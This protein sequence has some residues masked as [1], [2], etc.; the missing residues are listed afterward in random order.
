M[1]TTKMLDLEDY[2]KKDYRIKKTIAI[3]KIYYKF[4]RYK[5]VLKKRKINSNRYK[6]N[7]NKVNKLKTNRSNMIES[8]K[9]NKINYANFNYK[10]KVVNYLVYNMFNK[11]KFPFRDKNKNSFYFDLLI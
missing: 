10:V 3:N 9:V 4:L 11:I 2:F 7:Y 5:S 8:Y 6:K 1:M